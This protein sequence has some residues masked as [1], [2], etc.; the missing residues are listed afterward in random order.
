MSQ[1][2][3]V[4]DSILCIFI[5]IKYSWQNNILTSPTKNASNESRSLV[6]G[7]WM[8]PPTKV[9]VWSE[10]TSSVLYGPKKAALR[11]PNVLINNIYFW[12]QKRAAFQ[13][14]KVLCG[15]YAH[16]ARRYGRLVD[17]ETG[18]SGSCRTILQRLKDPQNICLGL[19][20]LLEILV[21]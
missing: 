10:E 20:E 19:L 18:S 15:G 14:R 16:R 17:K 21:S 7:K 11:L 2:I 6:G 4:Q 9:R 13:L 12:W 8:F 1:P 3:S 5:T